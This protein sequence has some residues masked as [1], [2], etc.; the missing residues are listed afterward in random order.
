MRFNVRSCSSLYMQLN[1]IVLTHKYHRASELTLQLLMH[2][3]MLSAAPPE[4]VNQYNMQSTAFL[5]CLG[6]KINMVEDE[7]VRAV[8]ESL[9]AMGRILCTVRAVSESSAPGDI[10]QGS[11]C[12]S[13][14]FATSGPIRSVE[15]SRALHP[16]FRPGCADPL[17]WPRR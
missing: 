17:C 13:S 5:Q 8:S 11:L 14:D 10:L 16:F 15:D 1:R 6:T 7:A 3:G 9:S 2:D 12:I 4:R